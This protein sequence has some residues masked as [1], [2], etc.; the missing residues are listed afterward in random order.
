MKFPVLLKTGSDVESG[1]ALHYLV[2]ANGVFKIVETETYRAVTR[3][4]GLI[5]ELLPEKECLRLRFPRVPASILR[6]VLAFLREVFVHH[7]G[8][9]IVILFYRPEAH[10]FRVG[11]PRQMI[12]GYRRW[13][14]SWRAY[15]RLRYEHA[16]RPPGYLCFGTIH[17]HA[18]TSAGST[19]IDCA[20][21]QFQDGLHVVYGNIDRSEPSRSASFVAS[22][23]RFSLDPDDVL[24]P[25]PVPDS[26]PDPAWMARVHRE[27]TGIVINPESLSNVVLFHSETSSGEDP[28]DAA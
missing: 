3:N 28:E 12:P 21:E 14:G 23:V 11:I 15:L 8:E 5:P 25:C 9:G 22:G 26:R 27:E 13:D 17:S 24:E 16:P 19:E 4:D 18:D 20:D 2:A 1:E 10:T 7:G 6:E